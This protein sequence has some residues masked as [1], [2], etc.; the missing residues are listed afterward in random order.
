MPSVSYQVKCI[1]SYNVYIPATQDDGHI[2]NTEQNARKLT[3][4]HNKLHARIWFT[5]G[6]S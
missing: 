6:D 4:C 5:K 3:T 2:C 1:V